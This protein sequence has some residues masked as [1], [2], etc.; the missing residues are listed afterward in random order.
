MAMSSQINNL[1]PSVR[2]DMPSGRPQDLPH[3]L[4]EPP[5]RVREIVA[6]EKARFTPEIFTQE[7]E[8][9]IVSD[10]TLQY[11]FEN[12]GHEVLYRTTPRGPEVVAVGFDEIQRVS[13]EARREFKT[14]MP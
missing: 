14:W 1:N 11:Y 12:L 7:A 8:E 13:P 4:I 2:G 3:G 5:E 6:K 10:L 9:R